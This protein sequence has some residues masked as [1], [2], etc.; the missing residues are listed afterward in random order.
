VKPVDQTLFGEEGNCLAACLASYFECEIAEV[1]DFGA[2]HDGGGDWWQA[3]RAFALPRGVSIVHVGAGWMPD[4][5]QGLHVQGGK[6]PRP[7]VTAGHVILV[8]N[9]VMVH[10]PHPSRAG[11]L[12]VEDYYLMVKMTSTG[13]S[14]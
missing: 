9:G 7:E 8:D 1:P 12:D 3:M 6:S 14:W 5:P 13:I 10:D 4:P 11:L 2:I